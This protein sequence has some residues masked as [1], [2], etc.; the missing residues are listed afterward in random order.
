MSVRAPRRVLAS[1]LV[2]LTA[3]VATALLAGGD[4]APFSSQSPDSES[5]QAGEALARASGVDPYFGLTA[6]VRPADPDVVERTAE[7]LRAD[8]AVAEVRFAR[9]ADRRSAYLIAG[10]RPGPLGDQ[11]DAARRV[12]DRL[13]GERRVRLGGRAA[14]YANGNDTATRDLV[15]ADLLAAPLILALAVWAFRGLIPALL[16]LGM[17]GFTIVGT[18]ALLRLGAQLSEVS[19]YALNITNALGLG[20]AIDYSL[21]LFFRYR[22]EAARSR[23]GRATLRRAVG[24]ARR[25]IATSSLTVAGAGL[26]LLVFPQP[27]LRS[28]GLGMALVAALAAASVLVVLPAAIALVGERIDALTPGRLRRAAS[29]EAGPASAGRWRRLARL[30]MRRPATVACLASALLLAAAMPAL[31]LRVTQVD[32]RVVPEGSSDR[33]VAEQIAREGLAGQAAPILLAVPG[34]EDVART[35][36]ARIADLPD[37]AAAEVS[38][39]RAAGAGLWRIDVVP[40]AGP[41]SEAGE[42]LVER[43]RA[44][45]VGLGVAVGGE[46]A[47]LVDLKEGIAARLG[48]CLAILAFVM[49]ASVWVATGSVVLPVKTLLM[50]ALTVA[51]ALGITSAIFQSGAFEGLLGYTSTG[52]LEA[53][54]VVL[55]AAIA[56]AL[57]TDYGVFLLRRIREARAAGA[58]DNEAVALG[59][60]RTGRVV[61]QAAVLL[62]VALGSLVLAEHSLVKQVGVG[63]AL[64][65]ALDASV[66]RALLVP[67]LMQLLGRA[68][69]WSPKALR[70]LVP[71]PERRPL[72]RPSDPR[73]AEGAELMAPTRYCDSE[74]REIGE[75]AVALTG[76]AGSEREA[77]ARLFR[78][79]RDD[80]SYAFGPWGVR[81]SET[82]G[83]RE[84]NCTNKANLLVALLRAAGI[85]GAYG[86]LRVDAQRYF[87]PI[88]PELLTRR[89]SQT[90]VHVHAAARVDGRW[91]K[92]DP[93][94]DADLARLTGHFSLQTRLVDWDATAD[95]TDVLDHEHVHADLGL[96]ADVDELL[97]RPARGAGPELFAA[98]NAYLQFVRSQ[99]VFASA[100]E[101]IEAYGRRLEADER[102]KPVQPRIASGA[103]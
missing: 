72:A 22:E 84:G 85:A 88:G 7:V 78:Y 40:G 6:L 16:S 58:S 81:A 47:A 25:T 53:S 83:R 49:L 79:V 82:L 18:Y 75:L 93:A 12:E 20:L 86:V 90:S 17:A 77:A 32:P 60:E 87:G 14:F 55:T 10:L 97:D 41:L 80:V 19:I 9:G 71:P 13:G 61:T 1:A 39:P 68:N 42:R 46:S 56:F 31:G 101:L 44:Q 38:A 15:R 24:R 3:L 35:A 11:L 33:Q 94:T 50:A 74:A 2:A 52:A 102:G 23:S 54:V 67:S 37:A 43:I 65:V 103:R 66:T 28:L 69:W 51:A 4:F 48:L 21:L 57:T 45:V 70:R 36:R 5:A 98:G 99:P 100:E 91:L 62:C 89:A 8:P 92:C 95:A 76:G 34:G 59:L 30:V 63:T 96:Y 29:R 73:P 26:S 27:F 64:A